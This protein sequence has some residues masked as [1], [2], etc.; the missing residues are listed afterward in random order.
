MPGNR[1]YAINDVLSVLDHDITP[2]AEDAYAELTS[3]L[4]PALL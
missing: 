3:A 1:L 2:D 4:K